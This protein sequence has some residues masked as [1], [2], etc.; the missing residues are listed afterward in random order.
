M[1]LFSREDNA[2]IS[3]SNAGV[4]VNPGLEGIKRGLHEIE[5]NAIVTCGPKALKWNFY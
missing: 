1:S 5:A 2:L 3:V 4:D